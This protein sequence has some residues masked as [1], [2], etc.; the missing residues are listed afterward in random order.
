MHRQMRLLGLFF[1]VAVITATTATA[2]ETSF[3]PQLY[4]FQNGVNFGTL[5]EEAATLKALMYDGIG[6]VSLDSLHDRI[7]A[8]EAVGLKVFSVYTNLGDRGIAKAIPHLK[9]RQ[10]TIELTIRKT[11]DDAAIKEIQELADLAA[12]AKVRIAIYPHAGFTIA[13]IDPALELV[14]QVDRPNVGVIFNLCHFLK[15]EKETDLEATL[16]RAG[17]KIF[18][19]STCGADQDGRDWNTLIQPLDQGSFEQTRLF[20]TLKNMGFKGAVGIQCYA[21][22]G[23]KRSNLQ[24]SEDAWKKILAR[25][26]EQE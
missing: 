2:K 16:A 4:A 22:Q 7:V 13:T 1:S 21:V 8:Y 20:G 3:A 14:K 12:Q 19:V 11:I 5:D 26:N 17:A 18:A 15:S 23:D 24:H 25:V 10:A 9:D 6:S